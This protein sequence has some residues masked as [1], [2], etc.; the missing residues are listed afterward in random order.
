MWTDRLTPVR[1]LSRL[2]LLMVLVGLLLLPTVVCQTRPGHA[3]RGPRRTLAE[4]MLN[5]WSRA[6][7]RV[8]G[9]AVQASGQLLPGPVLVV[10]NHISWLDIPVLHSLGAMSFVGKSEIDDWPLFGF[11]ARAGG[12]VFHRRG[13]HD[14]ADEVAARLVER[15][16]AGH[17]A[18][19]FPEG[20][21][22]PGEAINVFH[23]RMFRVA[24]EAP[25]PVQPAM[26]RYLR[27]GRR[28]PEMTFLDGEGFPA[29][30]LRLLGRPSSVADVHLLEPLAAVDRPR[31]EIASLA[32][33]AV[34]A[35]YDYEV[36]MG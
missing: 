28:D 21:I 3:L 24:V 17:R 30:V 14:S 25:C 2:L 6:L 18:A 11:L 26:I 8:F 16:N 23:A 19:I 1:I 35:A 29:N 31:K 33:R 34:R 5:T 15:L 32:Y 22:R 12:T 4:F 20:G 27:G 36:R 9:V 10:A 7:C 13:S